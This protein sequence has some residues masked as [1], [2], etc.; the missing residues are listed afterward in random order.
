MNSTEITKKFIEENNQF[1]FKGDKFNTFVEECKTGYV[2]RGIPN[3]V[4]CVKKI[5]TNSS[6]TYANATVYD[7]CYTFDEQGLRYTPFNLGKDRPKLSAFFGDSQAIGEGVKDNETLPYYFYLFN[8]DFLSYNYAHFGHGIDNM[9]GWINSVEFIKRFENREGEV[10]FIYRDDAIRKANN[11]P[12]SVTADLFNADHY[13]NTANKLL[14]CKE[15]LKNISNNLNLTVVIIPLS[16]SSDE[17]SNILHEKKI[18]FVNFF[19]LDL[20]FYTDIKSRFLDGAHTE[21][22]N[23]ILARL[24]SKY[25][26]VGFNPKLPNTTEKIE[27]YNQLIQKVKL[28]AFFMPYMVDFPLD[29]AGVIISKIKKHYAGVTNDSELIEIAKYSHSTKLELIKKLKQNKV[30][31]DEIFNLYINNSLNI[32]ETTL[33]T[34]PDYNSLP[35]NY[36]ERF[37]FL[38]NLYL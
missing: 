35:F 12:E 19:T 5:K 7:T 25:Y 28:E 15:K 18:N 6:L 33:K 22:S 27:N 36:R 9:L 34:S 11:L 17:I 10:F 1:I 16:F 26:K 21:F 32:T 4:G 20:E 13:E 38:F 37:E 31:P 29:D 3:S 23:Q 24:L 30:L 8:T 2:N 14:K